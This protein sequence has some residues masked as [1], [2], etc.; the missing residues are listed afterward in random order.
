MAQRI[1][2]IIQEQRITTPDSPPL[3]LDEEKKLKSLFV[4]TANEFIQKADP[5]KTFLIDERNKDIISGLWN[6]FFNIRGTYDLSK[7]LW[8]QGPPGTGKSAILYIF[9]EF[10]RK[11][12]MGFKVHT[13]N[14]IAM[15]FE[16]TGELDLFTSN[17]SGYSG[18][19]VVIAI[20]EI[21]QEPR[22]SVHFGTKRNV[23]Q[24]ILHTRYSYWQHTGLKTYATTNLDMVDV[25]DYYGD[26]IKDRIPHMFNII[27]M[28]GSSR[29]K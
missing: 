11:L 18:V 15:Q 1:K 26:A 10:N 4:Q 12:R 9:S 20:D 19:P 24:Y 6:Y 5:E 17:S 7:G 28:K 13:A 14:D 22:P 21:G 3:S 25:G 29:R 2:Q 23:I 27:S 8:L 16:Q